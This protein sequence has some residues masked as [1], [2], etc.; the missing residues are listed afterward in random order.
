MEFYWK[1]GKPIIDLNDYCLY[2]GE[3]ITDDNKGCY[4]LNDLWDKSGHS[5]K[6][7]YDIMKP[8]IDALN[9]DVTF[10]G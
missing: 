1:D 9:R 6:D 4:W 3:V 5:C 8:S 2:C 10:A 7:C